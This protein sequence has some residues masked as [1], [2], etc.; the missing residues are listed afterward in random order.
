MTLHLQSQGNVSPQKRKAQSQ[1]ERGGVG[2]RHIIW[3]FPWKSVD[4]P[5]SFN[6][7]CQD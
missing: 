4:Y 1:E 5:R 7:S 2:G 3:N 6:E